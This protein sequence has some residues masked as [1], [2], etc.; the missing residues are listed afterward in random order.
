MPPSAGRWPEENMQEQSA[1][2]LNIQTWFQHNPVLWQSFLKSEEQK[3]F[4]PLCL[5]HCGSEA[6][7]AEE[8]CRC[9][10]TLRAGDV[11][12]LLGRFPVCPRP[13]M[14]S[15]HTTQTGHGGPYL[16]SRHQGGGSRKIRVQGH[17]E[18]HSWLEA[19]LG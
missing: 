18:L 5:Q 8:L 3:P 9:G 14:G 6:D 2:W 4:F 11:L 12:Q 17:P 19:N 13:Q 10:K 1:S 15:P 16:S 7:E